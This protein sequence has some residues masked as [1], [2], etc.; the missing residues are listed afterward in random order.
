MF[1]EPR[2]QPSSI[3]RPTTRREEPAWL[4][5]P[6]DSFGG[7]IPLHEA[8]AR[9]EDAIIVFSEVRAYAEGCVLDVTAKLRRGEKLKDD[10]LGSPESKFFETLTSHH[11]ARESPIPDEL[12]RIGVQFQDGSKATTLE[13]HLFHYHN[14]QHLPEGKPLLIPVRG[15]GWSVRRDVLSIHDPLWLTPNPPGEFFDLVIEWPAAG[16]PETRHRVDGRAIRDAARHAA[17]YWPDVR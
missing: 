5:P 14:G 3:Q 8:V 13:Y 6:A 17:P 16:I 9:S 15:Y 10:W 11:Y 1:F 12:L 2:E 4:Q 7:V